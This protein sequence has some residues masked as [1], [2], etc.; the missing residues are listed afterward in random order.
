MGLGAAMA[1]A[2]GGE[3]RF[4]R[5]G[6]CGGEWR[7]PA[8]QWGG[9][10]VCPGCGGFIGRGVFLGHFQAVRRVAS[11]GFGDVIEGIDSVIGRRVAI[12]TLRHRLLENPQF[13]ARFAREAEVL[14]GLS[15]PN[16][17]EVYGFFGQGDTHYLVMEFVEGGSLLARIQRGG[18][19][20]EEELLRIATGAVRGL[21]AALAKRVLHR[22]IKPANM[23]FAGQGRI[24]LVDFGLAVSV[25]EAIAGMG[26]RIGSPHYTAP[27]R[28][29]GAA[30][31][32][33][34]DMYSLGVT[35]FHAAAGRTPFQATDATVM[36][37][38]HL[39]AQRVSVKTFAP[40]LSDD[41]VALINRC[42]ARRPEDRFRTYFELLDALESAQ[43][44]LVFAPTKKAA[45]PPDL[46]GA[47]PES[48][49]ALRWLG[50]GAAAVLL[51]AGGIFALKSR[52]RGPEFDDTVAPPA[53][54]RQRE[55]H[56]TAGNE[57]PNPLSPGPTAHT[58]GLGPEMLANPSFETAA[59]PGTLYVHPPASATGTR[60]IREYDTA[61][62]GYR[63][64]CYQI[65]PNYTYI[66]FSRPL[67]LP[68]G[69]G[70]NYVLTF[71]ARSTEPFRVGRISV[72]KR[73]H[74]FSDY[75][76]RYEG[77]TPVISDQ[78][79]TY[80]MVCAA[81]TNAQDARV[82]FFLGN[83]LPPGS[84][85]YID[86][87]SLRASAQRQ[88][89]STVQKATLPAAGQSAAGLTDAERG[90]VARWKLDETNGTTAV[91]SSAMGNDL[92][93]FG[94]TD[95]AA[96]AGCAGS[97]RG[98]NTNYY[99]IR[100][101]INGLCGDAITFGCWI[102]TT[103]S[104]APH[105]IL[106]Y[107]TSTTAADIDKEFLVSRPS[108]IRVFRGRTF[109][110]STGVNVND[111]RW[112]HLAVT[113]KSLDGA[114][115]LYKDGVRA[116][117]GTLEVGTPLR[118]D[119]ALV[120]GQDQDAVGGGFDPAQ[121]FAGSL[122]DYRIYT[123]VL[124]PEAI[125]EMAKSPPPTRAEAPPGMTP[126]IAVNESP[127]AYGGSL[128]AHWKLDETDGLIAN[129]SS[130]NGV[131]GSLK[132]GPTWTTNGMAGGALGFDGRD[133]C[134]VAD[135]VGVNST[136]GGCNTIAFWMYWNGDGSRAQMP[137]SWDGLYCLL[138]FHGSFG[139]NTGTGD[140]LGIPST[141][142]AGQ[143]RHVAVVFPNGI[144]S[145]DN[146]KIYIDG[147]RQTVTQRFGS[148]LSRAASR[149]IFLSGCGYSAGYKF[150]G[151][152]DDVRVYNRELTREEV[153]GLY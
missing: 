84:T 45:P 83:T 106:S 142:L 118:C 8:A 57:A 137:F 37:W 134:V 81:S 4:C 78:W 107:Q 36:A 120:I 21:L 68:I 23:L 48:S 153:Q 17:A 133:D 33:R 82:M 95:P 40:G 105:A 112:H 135:G 131:P 11:G 64:D 90:L 139:I 51:F 92:T 96:W 111:G 47:S 152:V 75:M 15:H 117:S 69:V 147:V 140:L 104:A 43:K 89:P 62:A 77:E 28:I 80:R 16:V 126:Y 25:E 41:T 145:P 138:F 44:E 146:A 2:D 122:G 65:G 35:L 31:D 151:I 87:L 129:D 85:L 19:V 136:P 3:E 32:F 60:T 99:L 34:G 49:W 67:N 93:I 150:G 58:G 141:G 59:E 7:I 27:E 14:A 115:N 113:W 46:V 1:G 71:R 97:F 30:E 123:N 116:Y 143:W 42:M 18:R 53:D 125:A 86:T 103:G 88:A 6:T 38:K 148:P 29:E 54:Q 110:R 119:G 74:P 56:T 130:R 94:T 101:P 108:D 144:P 66:Q 121:A 12:K 76:S 149:K 20:P 127:Y 26:E 24:K 114:L 9:D 50:I 132:N 61:P 98:G 79:A 39:K 22:D 109:L 63:I 13:V 72:Q 73:T 55:D 124:N 5:C 10:M 100:R 91:D 128:A 102:K 70:T 52:D